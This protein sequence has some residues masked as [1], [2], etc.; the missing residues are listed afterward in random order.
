VAT[1]D[2]PVLPAAE[3]HRGRSRTPVLFW[4]LLG[5]GFSASFEPSGAASA[6][7]YGE[8]FYP[9][10]IVLVVLFTAIFSTISVIE[11]RR[12]GF[13]QAVL[14]APVSRAAVVLGKILGGRRSRSARLCCSFWQRRSSA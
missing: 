4:L 10:T 11:D 13:L 1:G 12:E 6:W 9:G 3:P 8:Y 14:V 5:A 2:R 7:R